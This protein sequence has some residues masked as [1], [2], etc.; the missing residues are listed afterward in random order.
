MDKWKKRVA[1]FAL[2]SMTLP[3]TLQADGDIEAGKEKAGPCVVCHGKDGRAAIEAYPHIGGQ[4]EAYLVYALKAYK[5][6][7]R[8]GGQAAIMQGMAANLSEQDI[9]DLAAYFAS[10]ERK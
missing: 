3:A 4:H 9:A 2:V 8:R 7:L 1:M 10:L 6:N 5:E